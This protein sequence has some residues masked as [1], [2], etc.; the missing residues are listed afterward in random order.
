[1]TTQTAPNGRRGVNGTYEDTNM[2]PA[3]ERAY[4]AGQVAFRKGRPLSDNP[5]H[6]ATDANAR[7]LR[8]WRRGYEDAASGKN[9]LATSPALNHA[10]NYLLQ[11]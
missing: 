6:A 11:Q 1:M 2:K 7:K 4:R 3:E 9:E 8:A 10:L 5:H